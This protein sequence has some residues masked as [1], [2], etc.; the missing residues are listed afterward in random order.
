[1]E[2]QVVSSPPGLPHPS[3]MAGVN[4]DQSQSPKFSPPVSRRDYYRSLGESVANKVALNCPPDGLPTSPVMN[5]SAATNTFS[6]NEMSDDN[7]VFV[8]LRNIPYSY[9]R[10]MVL[11]LIDSMGFENEY[12]FFYLPMNLATENC[13]GYALIMFT[14]LRVAENFVEVFHGLKDWFMQEW[15]CSGKAV[16]RAVLCRQTQEFKEVVDFYSNSGIMHPSVREEFKPLLFKNGK[17][18]DF[19]PPTKVLKAPRRAIQRRD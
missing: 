12:L 3:E 16:A 8:T 10:E 11:R 18:V 17:R 4:S 9:T 13:V 2:L 19:P 1:M 15:G 14:S 6:A 5:I 7:C